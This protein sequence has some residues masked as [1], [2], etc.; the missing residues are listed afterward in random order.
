MAYTNV[1][2]PKDTWV[3]I[4]NATTRFQIKSFSTAYHIYAVEDSVLPT[5][6]P[7]EASNASVL[8]PFEWYTFEYAGENLYIYSA[9]HDINIVKDL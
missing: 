7:D 5:G 4:G 6:T 9:G 2:V 1:A 8:Q 3:L